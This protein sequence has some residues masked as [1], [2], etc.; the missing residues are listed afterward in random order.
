MQSTQ[1]AVAENPS[2][3]LAISSSSI[4]LDLP[5]GIS[6][7]ICTS[8]MELIDIEKLQKSAWE[9]SNMV[10]DIRS[11]LDICQMLRSDLSRYE[12]NSEKRDPRPFALAYLRLVKSEDE[13]AQAASSGRSIDVLEQTW[14]DIYDKLCSAYHDDKDEAKRI[15]D[16]YF[17]QAITIR[18]ALNLR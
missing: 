4:L 11:V 15:H 18:Q 7:G 9:S 16:A 1:F 17:L 2:S 14:K 13:V 8:R 12:H 10:D 5:L 6:S 3:L